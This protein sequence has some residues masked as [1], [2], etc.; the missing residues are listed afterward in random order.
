MAMQANVAEET[1]KRI[2]R[3]RIMMLNRRRGSMSVV[4]SKARHCRGSIY[5][6]HLSRRGAAART[7]KSGQQYGMGGARLWRCD[8]NNGGER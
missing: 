2:L 5:T 6:W 1:E 3:Q 8:V 4:I 7:T